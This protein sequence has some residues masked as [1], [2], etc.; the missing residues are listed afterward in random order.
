MKNK[1]LSQIEYE[2]ELSTLFALSNKSI[3]WC[4]GTKRDRK[5]RPKAALLYQRLYGRFHADFIRKDT[6][7]VYLTLDEGYEN[8]YSSDIL[9]V[10]KK[11]RVSAVF[12][13]TMNYAVRNP[14][15]IQ[16]MID[17]GHII[18]NHSVT[19]PNDGMPSMSLEKQIAEIMGV[20]EHMKREFGYTMHLFRYP[21]GIFSK[22]SLALM[23]KMNYQSVFWSFAYRDWLIDK[24]P[25]PAEAVELLLNQ[26]H[27]GAIY[28]L[29]AVS[30][31]NAQ[32]L[33]LF[34]DQA[35]MRGYEFSSYDVI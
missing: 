12:F 14:K 7:K 3:A 17:E 10:L 6:E 32:I 27:P 33:E 9:N 8:G 20:H 31:T 26:L 5:M 35:K 16:R 1:L 18:G 30:A 24:Q 19:H 13:V 4:V 2:V 23:R 29:H 25:D 34:I 11:K 28:L 15:L 21:G 22:Q